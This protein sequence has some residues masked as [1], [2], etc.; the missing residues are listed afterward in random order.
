MSNARTQIDFLGKASFAFPL[1]LIVIIGSIYLWFSMGEKKYGI[2]FRGGYEFIVKVGEGVKSDAIRKELDEAGLK[3]ATVQ[4]FEGE[5]NKYSIRLGVTEGSSS[6]EIKGK[7]QALIGTSAMGGGELLQS[8]YVGPT[9]GAE[10]KEKAIISLVL[11]VLGILGYIAFRFEFS[12]ALGAVVA[13]FH[14]GIVCTGF[15]LLSGHLLSMG[16]LA[17]ALTIIGYSV[18]DTIVI[19]DR[20]R[21]ELRTAK[22]P[23]MAKIMNDS[24]NL[25]LSRTVITNLL[26]L[27]SAAALLIWGGGAIADL[28]MFL[29]VGIIAGTYS[30]IYIAAPV[31]L[32]WEKLRPR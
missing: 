21:D 9:S 17:A 1:S 27:F 24:I 11:C 25:M 28:S 32:T 10:L 20:V 18:N 26:T 13:L 19:F 30:T 7:I 29:V 15:Y 6:E 31:V 23:N 2:D 16:T 22:N 8:E 14:D 5:G 12:F 3:E 4:S